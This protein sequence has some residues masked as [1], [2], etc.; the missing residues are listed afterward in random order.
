MEWCNDSNH[1]SG[2]LF[3]CLWKCILK[4]L[5]PKQERAGRTSLQLVETHHNEPLSWMFEQHTQVMWLCQSVTLVVF[6]REGPQLPDTAH[7]STLGWMG[8]WMDGWLDGWLVGLMKAPCGY[9]PAPS[10]V[11]DGIS[12]EETL[13]G[14]KKVINAML[15]VGPDVCT[16]CSVGCLRCLLLSMSSGNEKPITSFWWGNSIQWH[17]KDFKSLSCLFSYWSKHRNGKLWT[18]KSCLFKYSWTIFTQGWRN[19]FY[20]NIL[21]LCHFHHSYFS[22]FPLWVLIVP[23]MYVIHIGLPPSHFVVWLL[24]VFLILYPPWRQ[25]LDL[26]YILIC[27]TAWSEPNIT[28][29]WGTAWNEWKHV[30]YTKTGLGVQMLC[31]DVVEMGCV[32]HWK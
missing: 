11:I 23:I 21:Y 16:L 9:P 17:V 10:W 6:K 12:E 29:H 31:W 15:P 25:A 32:L 30:Y 8:G 18:I 14:R 26:K 3:Q 13:A 2:W 28:Q 7:C 19:V 22:L 5:S 24:Y 4:Q 27:H 20:A 1:R